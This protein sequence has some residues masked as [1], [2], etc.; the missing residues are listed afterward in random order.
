M[1]CSVV[2]HWCKWCML[3][4]SQ[5]ALILIQTRG[6]FRHD[7]RHG[8]SVHCSCVQILSFYA[9]RWPVLPSC[10]QLTLINWYV[11]SMLCCHCWMFS[12]SDALPMQSYP[13]KV[14]V[15]PLS[16]QPCR[17][18]YDITYLFSFLQI[19]VSIWNRWYISWLTLWRC[20][21]HS[22]RMFILLVE[23]GLVHRGDCINCEIC[24]FC[25]DPAFVWPSLRRADFDSAL[26]VNPFRV[27]VRVP[28]QAGDACQ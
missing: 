2:S 15:D 24:H 12:L 8:V 5:R 13:S 25:F 18:L 1:A 21:L 20:W 7:C 16:V 27:F 4:C 3:P 22:C 6:K 9:T 19:Y 10:M 23:Y 26:L 28:E 17:S 11:A 14:W